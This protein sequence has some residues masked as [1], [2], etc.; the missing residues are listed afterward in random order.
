MSHKQ[1]GSVAQIADRAGRAAVALANGIQPLPQRLSGV[2]D[3]IKVLNA[4]DFPPDLR[5]RFARIHETITAPESLEDFIRRMTRERAAQLA[6]DICTL[7]IDLARRE[8]M[9]SHKLS[10]DA[11]AVLQILVTAAGEQLSSGAR[12]RDDGRRGIDALARSPGLMRGLT[13]LRK[14]AQLKGTSRRA[15][16]SP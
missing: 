16:T 9:E 12:R 6:E 10:D 4:Q 3:E 8:A 13:E 5:P 14:V 1:S 7:A 15:P 2:M 11:R